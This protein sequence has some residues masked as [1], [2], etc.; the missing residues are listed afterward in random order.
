[1]RLVG[2]SGAVAIG[3]S[4]R[5]RAFKIVTG[6]AIYDWLGGGNSEHT[7]MMDNVAGVMAASRRCHE[8]RRLKAEESRIPSEQRSVI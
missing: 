2:G 4:K 7:K 5:G 3:C 6:V 8:D 1:V